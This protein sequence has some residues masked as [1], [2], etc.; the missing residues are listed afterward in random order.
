MTQAPKTADDTRPPA[1]HIE[2]GRRVAGMFDRIA[3]FYDLLNRS[4]SLGQDV[5]WRYRLARAAR[6][7]P[8][9]LALDLAAGT[10][11]VAL[12]LTRQQPSARVLALDFSEPMLRRG[13]AKLAKRRARG[14]QP[15]LADGRCLPL[16]DACLD[17]AT[18]AFGI[19]NIKPRFEAFAELHRCLKPGGRLCV[20]EFGSGRQRIWKGMYNI[21]LKRVLPLIGRMVSG[22]AGAYRYLADTIA[23]FPNECA[24]AAE[25]RAAGF[26]EVYWQPLMSGI[27]YIHVA[28][29]AGAGEHSASEKPEAQVRT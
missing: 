23:E 11:D 29:K 10:L 14:I 15:G 19:R 17:A 8:D 1:E 4:L 6:V 26:P 21:Y 12:E 24:L 18:I 28:R 3:R 5:Y 25:M 7:P 20:L 2:H 9:G 22:D 27:V 13:Q 16:P